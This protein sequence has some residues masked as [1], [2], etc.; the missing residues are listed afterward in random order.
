MEDRP[1]E[2]SAMEKELGMIIKKEVWLLKEMLDAARQC[3][4]NN[5]NN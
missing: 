3:Y 2:K 1:G 5:N 4:F